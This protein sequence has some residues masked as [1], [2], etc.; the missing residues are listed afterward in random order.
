MSF[1]WWMSSLPSLVMATTTP[2]TTPA[3]N[4]LIL[5]FH[6]YS[7]AGPLTQGYS[8]PRPTYIVSRLPSTLHHPTHASLT[9]YLLISVRSFE[10]NGPPLASFLYGQDDVA[11]SCKK[12]TSSLSSS[13]QRVHHRIIPNEWHRRCAPV[14]QYAPFD[15]AWLRPAVEK[16]ERGAVWVQRRRITVATMP[17]SRW[18]AHNR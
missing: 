13:P 5:T 1:Q 14:H 8:L 7:I 6:H 12:L 2:S 9:S 4:P 18:V 15:V 3:A 10:R 17:T 16:R 11:R